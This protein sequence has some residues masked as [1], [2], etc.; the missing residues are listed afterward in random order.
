MPALPEVTCG[1]SVIPVKLPVI[2]FFFF[3]EIEKKILRSFGISGDPQKPK[4]VLKK[5]KTKTEITHILIS[6]LNSKDT[7]LKT[8]W[9]WHKDTFRAMQLNRK[10]GNKP[11][12]IGSNDFWHECQD[13]SLG[14]DSVF[15]N[16]GWENEISTCKEMKLAPYLIPHT[17]I[18]SK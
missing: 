3:P 7:V 6:K 1:F 13:L 2:F 16:W 4:T 15:N 5:R 11:W 18:N 17:K 9:Q 14:K 10:P 12:D 8:V